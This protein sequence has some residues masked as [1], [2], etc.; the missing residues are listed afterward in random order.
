MQ[1]LPF[2]YA[3]AV[4]MNQNFFNFGASP[5]RKY[6]PGFIKHAR[7]YLFFFTLPP[8]YHIPISSLQR[9]LPVYCFLHTFTMKGS[10]G[11]PCKYGCLLANGKPARHKENRCAIRKQENAAKVMAGILLNGFI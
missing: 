6:F 9:S 8:H 7:D 10:S 11:P 5:D 3:I 2:R 1:N 4:V